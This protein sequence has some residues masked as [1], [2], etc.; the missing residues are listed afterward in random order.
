[1]P[2]EWSPTDIIL[3]FGLSSACW[4]RGGG[5]RAVRRSSSSSGVMIRRSQVAEASLGIDAEAA[6]NVAIC[7]KLELFSAVEEYSNDKLSAKPACPPRRCV[8]TNVRTAAG[9]VRQR[10]RAG[11]LHRFARSGR[12]L[13]R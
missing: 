7:A 2:S 3:D 6:R 1:M 8:G 9:P 5:M 4:T 10:T 11:L 13:A 12:R